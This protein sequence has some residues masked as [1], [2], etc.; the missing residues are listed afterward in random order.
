MFLIYRIPFPDDL[1]RSEPVTPNSHSHVNYCDFP[2]KKK[3]KNEAVFQKAINI[4]GKWPS[5]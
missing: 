1:A 2:K 5:V 4:S 3:I